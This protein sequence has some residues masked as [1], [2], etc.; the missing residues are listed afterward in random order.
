MFKSIKMRIYALALL[1]LLIIAITAIYLSSSSIKQLGVNVLGTTENAIMDAERNRLKSLLHSANALLEPYIAMPGDSGKEEGIELLKNFVFDEG[2]GY[3]FGYDYTGNRLLLGPSDAGLGNNYWD[4]QDQTQQYLIRDMVDIAKGNKENFYTY[5]FPKPGE[6]EP[7]PKFSYIS[8]IDK[9][10]MF[11]GLGLYFDSVEGVL[12][13]INGD[14]SDAQQSS[15]SKT[16]FSIFLVIAITAVLATLAIR[17]ISSSLDKLSESVD[18]L[19]SGRGDLTMTLPMRGISELDHIASS[20]NTFIGSLA[21]DIKNLKAASTELKSMSVAAGS[22]QKQ[23][24]VEVESQRENTLQVAAAIEE[25]SATASEIASNAENTSHIAET[26]HSEI[27]EV[28]VQVNTSTDRISDLS[29]V[30]NNV[31][32]SV[33]ELVENVQG[34]HQA[35]GVIQSISEQTNLLA[36]NAAIEAARAGEQGRGFAVV[37]DE[38][39]TLAQRSQQSTVEIGEIL[40]KL[41]DSSKRSSE[42]MSTTIESRSAVIEA[43]NTIKTLV[44]STTNSIGQLTEMNTMVATSANEQSAVATDITKA[45]SDIANSS[46]EIQ[47]GTEETQSQFVEV[48]RLAENVDDVSSGF[49]V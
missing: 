44:E 35:L 16:T 7:S 19:A 10:N 11:I 32:S 20:F 23:L 12:N 29:T 3:I 38:V 5:H 46:E 45:V 48:N 6:D 14:L 17:T 28:L 22:K 2:V 27:N 39:R 47:Q 30:L 4:L 8:G 42:E 1:P 49:K 25:M 9:W 43:M 26:V 37:A 40:D 21:E 33:S 24:S 34:I 18:G 41:S 36:L 13:N 31:D 15:V